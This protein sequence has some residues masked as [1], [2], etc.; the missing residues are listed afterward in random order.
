MKNWSVKEVVMATCV[1]AALGAATPSVADTPPA[2]EA[3][4]K[5]EMGQEIDDAAKAAIEAA[6]HLITAMQ[7]FVDSLPQYA[8][9]E[10]LE[11]GDILIRRLPDKSDEASSDGDSGDAE[12]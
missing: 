11:N 9:P 12:Q 5:E 4:T 3:A 2:E 7:M 6:E 1:V 8:A 10:I